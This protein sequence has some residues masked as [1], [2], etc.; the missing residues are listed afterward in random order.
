MKKVIRNGKVAVLHSPGFGAGWYTWG[1]PKELIFDPDIVKLVENEE[2]DKIKKLVKSKGY[3]D[4]YCGGVEN[5]QITWLP[6][7]TKFIINEYDGNESI[8]ILSDIEYFEA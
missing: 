1:A 8:E 3:K 6:K 7:G 2:Y 4:L 5:L